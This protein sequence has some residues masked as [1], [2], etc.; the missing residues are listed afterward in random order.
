MKNLNDNELDQLL[1]VVDPGFDKWQL[2]LLRRR[3]L[4]KASFNRNSRFSLLALA[5]RCEPALLAATLV[6]GLWLGASLPLDHFYEDSSMASMLQLSGNPY[7]L[8]G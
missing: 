2:Q 5:W 3:I 4:L 7:S 1:N 6:L 8:G